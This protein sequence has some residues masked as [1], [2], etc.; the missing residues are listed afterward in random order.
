MEQL[1]HALQ[2]KIY[3]VTSK[4]HLYVQL[5]FTACMKQNLLR[6]SEHLLCW[7]AAKVC[8]RKPSSNKQLHDFSN[9]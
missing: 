4:P 9:D 8:I 6:I 2:T 1:F 3:K 5:T 7:Q